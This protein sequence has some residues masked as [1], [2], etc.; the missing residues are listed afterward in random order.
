MSTWKKILNQILCVCSK[1]HSTQHALFIL[2]LLQQKAVHQSILIREILMDLSKTFAYLPHDVWFENYNSVYNILQLY[3]VLVQVQSATSK[4][5][6]DMQYSKL[7][8]PVV[9]RLKDL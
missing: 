7:G 6:F 8:V 9:S 1:V 3:N 5:K 2:L 4:A